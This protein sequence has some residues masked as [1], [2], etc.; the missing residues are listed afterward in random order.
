MFF[1]NTWFDKID[2]NFLA[3]CVNSF[4]QDCNLCLVVVSYGV[5]GTTEIGI[6]IYIVLPVSLFQ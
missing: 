2:V 5:Q 6:K 4:V 1:L 3:Q